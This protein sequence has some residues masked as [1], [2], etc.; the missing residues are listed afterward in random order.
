MQEHE[1][2]MCGRRC[3]EVD[4]YTTASGHAKIMSVS[5]LNMKEWRREEEDPSVPE[6]K[7][8]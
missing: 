3:E 6:G 8:M 2:T 7:T 1:N 4:V 5:R